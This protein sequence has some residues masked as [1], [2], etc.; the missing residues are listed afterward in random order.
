M[1]LPNVWTTQVGHSSRFSLFRHRYSF[2]TLDISLHAEPQILTH[3]DNFA[4][5]PVDSSPLKEGLPSTPVVLPVTVR[6]PFNYDAGAATV[7]IS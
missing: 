5:Q 6:L 4:T 7:R 3:N 2:W 1:P